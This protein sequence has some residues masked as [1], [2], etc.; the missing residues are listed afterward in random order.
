MRIDCTSCAASIR[1]GCGLSKLLACEESLVMCHSA[2]QSH[3]HAGSVKG[4]DSMEA[5]EKNGK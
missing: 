5:L 2:I 4:I 3:E 1:D